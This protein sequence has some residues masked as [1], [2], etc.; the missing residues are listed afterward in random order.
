[1]LF[2]GGSKMIR[3]ANKR[4]TE[5]IFDCVHPVCLYI[6]KHIFQHN[7]NI[8]YGTNTTTTKCQ[9]SFARSLCASA[10]SAA[11]GTETKSHKRIHMLFGVERAQNTR[12]RTFQQ[13]SQ[14]DRRTLSAYT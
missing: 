7:R 10:G 3:E 5:H 4:D 9:L 1:M 14:L 2:S 11:R 6:L 12:R 8:R 13:Q